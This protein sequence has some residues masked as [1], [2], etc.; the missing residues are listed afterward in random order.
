MRRS[1]RRTPA[2]LGRRLALVGCAALA[3]VALGPQATPQAKPADKLA[4]AEAAFPWQNEELFYKIKVNG[5]EAVHAVVRVGEVRQV[6]DQPYVAIAAKAKSVGLFHTIYPM[7]DKANT[8]VDPTHY[9]PLRSEKVFRE[10]GKGRTY[11]VDYLHPLFKAKIH[12]TY[13]KGRDREEESQRRYTRP[14]P[15]STHDVFSWFFELRAE[16]KLEV[17]DELSYYVYDG[18]KLSRVDLKVKGTERV[19]TPMGWFNATRMDFTREILRA[20]YHKTKKGEGPTEPEL[21]VRVPA[22]PTGS[23]WLSTDKRRLPVKIEM[24]SKYGTGEVVL[25]RYKKK[26]VTR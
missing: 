7:D 17:G 11:K 1:H 13:H 12:K 18:W 20:R 10:A 5:S 25:S 26:P 21:K 24:G 22:K 15:G 8:F 2:A 23:L 9:H 14:I 4:Q 6:K 19:L 16:P 3:L